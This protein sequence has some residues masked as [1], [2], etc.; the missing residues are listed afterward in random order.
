M[1]TLYKEYNSSEKK[2][3]KNKGIRKFLTH[4]LSIGQLQK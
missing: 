2:I 3:L 1:I 4:K